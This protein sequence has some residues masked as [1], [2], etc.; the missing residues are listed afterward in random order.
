MD[1]SERY[2][3]HIFISLELTYQNPF[4]QNQDFKMLRWKISFLTLAANIN[5]V[6]DIPV[7]Y[8]RI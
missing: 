4:A 1:C 7:S 8:S 2:E 3:F 6:N 5:P